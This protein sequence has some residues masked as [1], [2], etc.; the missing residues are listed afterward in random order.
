M[1]KLITKPLV[2]DDE[3]KCYYYVVNV[4]IM[5][6]LAYKWSFNP[7]HFQFSEKDMGCYLQKL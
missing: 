5:L 4:D 6:Y 3:I 2:D 7:F 1:S